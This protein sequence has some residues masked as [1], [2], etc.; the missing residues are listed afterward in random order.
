MKEYLPVQVT[1]LAIGECLDWMCFD[2]YHETVEQL[3]EWVVAGGKVGGAAWGNVRKYGLQPLPLLA[4][5]NDKTRDW[6]IANIHR[7]YRKRKSYTEH[8]D[9]LLPSHALF[10]TFYFRFA[11]IKE[12]ISHFYDLSFLFN[13]EN[14][15]DKNMILLKKACCQTFAARFAI[16]NCERL[17]S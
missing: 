1:G 14:A 10:L 4:C 7:N 5:A 9:D 16:L 8:Q 6:K 12:S 3:L 11:L 2:K 13:R 15:Q 17:W